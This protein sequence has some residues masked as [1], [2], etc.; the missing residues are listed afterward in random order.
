MRKWYKLSIIGVVIVLIYYT[1]INNTRDNISRVKYGMTMNNVQNIIGP[2]V[3]TYKFGPLWH[4]HPLNKSANTELFDM[5]YL[6][7][8]YYD[9][10]FKSLIKPYIKRKSITKV[11]RIEY[12]MNCR[13]IKMDR[14]ASPFFV[15]QILEERE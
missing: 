6:C 12:D 10:P 1:Y 5:R 4:C 7:E 15:T 13:V 2:P 9:P 11:L 8:Y 3:T 14:S